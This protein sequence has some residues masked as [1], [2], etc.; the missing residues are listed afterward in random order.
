MQVFGNFMWI[1]S[2]SYVSLIWF[3]ACVLPKT[4]SL[5]N[6]SG[7]DFICCSSLSADR[8]DLQLNLNECIILTVLCPYDARD[9]EKQASPDKKNKLYSSCWDKN[10][11]KTHCAQYKFDTHCC[12]NIF[13][14]TVSISISRY[15]IHQYLV[16]V[17]ANLSKIKTIKWWTEQ[18]MTN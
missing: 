1:F 6:S 18:N 12:R 14:Q 17:Y 13:R 5:F 16:S 7:G 10:P 9:R 15:I 3:I 4:Y 8:Y 11:W 2:C